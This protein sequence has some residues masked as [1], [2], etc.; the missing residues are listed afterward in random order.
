MTQTNRLSGYQLQANSPAINAGTSIDG[1]GGL[2]FWGNPLYNNAADIG[3][4][5]HQE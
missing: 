3:A 5:E 2:D 4:H 1:N